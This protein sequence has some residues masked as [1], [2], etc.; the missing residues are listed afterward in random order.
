[1]ISSPPTTGSAFR[2]TDAGVA[3]NLLL[4]NGAGAIVYSSSISIFDAE[5]IGL[6]LDVAVVTQVVIR[7]RYSADN[8]T[9]CEEQVE[10]VGALVAGAQRYSLAIKEWGPLASGRYA[11]ERAVTYH[12]VRVGIY[13]VG[14]PVAG[15]NVQLSVERQRGGQ[16]QRMG[17]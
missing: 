8:T 4:G 15:D 2:W 9:F 16:L 10:T 3:P 1:M 14:A 6:V 11:V 5:E 7:L 12:W 17:G 13:S